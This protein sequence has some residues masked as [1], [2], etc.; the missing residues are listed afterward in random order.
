MIQNEEKWH[1]LVV[2][3]LSTLL[4]GIIATNNGDFYLNFDLI[5]VNKKQTWI[6]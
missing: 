2:T 3:R 4:R 6:A 1:C 5:F